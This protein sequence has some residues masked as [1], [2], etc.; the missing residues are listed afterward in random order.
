MPKRS[1]I[2]IDESEFE[3]D[4]RPTQ[5][6]AP[7]LEALE[8]MRSAGAPKRARVRPRTR[9][10]LTPAT[11]S[12]LQVKTRSLGAPLR[13]ATSRIRAV[14]SALLEGG[15]ARASLLDEQEVASTSIPEPRESGARRI[16]ATTAPARDRGPT[17]TMKLPA[18]RP[19]VLAP[20]VKLPARAR[21]RG[22]RRVPAW[23]LAAG[24]GL[25]CVVAVW[26]V[27]GAVRG[28]A[29]REAPASASAPPGPATDSVPASV[30]AVEPPTSIDLPVAAPVAP[31]PPS[32]AP[33]ARPR[34]H[35]TARRP[36]PQ[37][38]SAVF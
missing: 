33:A 4:E 17:G 25:L 21:A 6:G 10:A 11:Q 13:T 2:A 9:P 19:R 5:P 7:S 37:T 16:P 3:T 14:A 29:G 20:T 26:V 38:G 12:W 35:G 24:A 8:A 31:A 36:A 28:R 34:P 32:A 1:P 27:L 22:W 18:R 15:G 30:P 23:V